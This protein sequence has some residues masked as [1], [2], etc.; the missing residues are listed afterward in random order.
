M[1]L[2]KLRCAIRHR[3]KR[4][5]RNAFDSTFEIPITLLWDC[6]VPKLIRLRFKP[7]LKCNAGQ[8]AFGAVIGR[9][10]GYNNCAVGIYAIPLIKTHAID[11]QPAFFGRCI[12]Y[13][14]ARA[15]AK[16]IDPSAAG[17]CSHLI[18]CGGQQGRR[19]SILGFAN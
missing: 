13:I 16:G 1:Q 6:P 15:H 3:W 10:N 19:I 12:D 17:V 11:R 7:A 4:P 14:A 5:I 9:R 8:W 18:G 2:P